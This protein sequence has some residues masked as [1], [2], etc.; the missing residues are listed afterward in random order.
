MRNIDKKA[1][2]YDKEGNL[3]R[4]VDY[5]NKLHSYTVYE[6]EDL[7]DKLSNDKDENDRIKDPNAVNNV[8]AMLFQFYQKY[9]NPHAAEILSK[10]AEQ[11]KERAELKPT[12]EQ[13]Q[14]ALTELNEELNDGSTDD[15]SNGSTDNNVQ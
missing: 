9:G 1:N 3:I 12:S 13:V 5:D 7:L 15:N 14:E 2:I 6:L 10:L 4:H 8:N 11:A